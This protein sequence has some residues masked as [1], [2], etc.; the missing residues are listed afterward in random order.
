MIDGEIV[1]ERDG[2]VILRHATGWH[3]HRQLTPLERA[4]AYAASVRARNPQMIVRRLTE[5]AR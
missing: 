3:E 4:Q 5:R 2:W 1:F